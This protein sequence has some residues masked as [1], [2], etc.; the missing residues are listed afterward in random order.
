MGDALLLR[1]R[2]AAEILAVSESQLLK[3]ER[4]GVL[5]PVRIPDLRAVRYRAAD[6]RSLAANITVGRLSSETPAA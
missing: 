4:A 3:W 1:R 6:V 2:D 5:T